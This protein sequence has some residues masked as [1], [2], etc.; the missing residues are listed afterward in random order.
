MALAI[1]LSALLSPVDRYAS[2][3]PVGSPADAKDGDG[4]LRET[5]ADEV[6]ATLLET[7]D[8]VLALL[9]TVRRPEAHE[10]P[11]ALPVSFLS[12]RRAAHGAAR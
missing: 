3:R 2:R 10:A 9:P 7:R 4:R 6:G 5:G 11:A 8:Q 1:L 12:P